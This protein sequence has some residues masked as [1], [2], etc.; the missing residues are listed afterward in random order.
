MTDVV[1][2]ERNGR[3]LTGKITNFPL[4][5]NRFSCP[6]VINITAFHWLL[7]DRGSI[8]PEVVFHEGYGDEGSRGFGYVPG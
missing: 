3:K 5:L 1:I 7:D 2:S 8:Y 4:I 6:D